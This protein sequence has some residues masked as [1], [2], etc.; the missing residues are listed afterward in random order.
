MRQSRV[1]S[2]FMQ[3]HLAETGCFYAPLS[4]EFGGTGDCEEV[5]GT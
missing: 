4:K 1:P 5:Q 2:F 3:L